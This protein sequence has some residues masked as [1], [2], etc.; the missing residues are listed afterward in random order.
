M[1][2]S[3]FSVGMLA[4]RAVS[5]ARRSRGLP[6]GSPPPALAATVISRISLVQLAARLLSVIAFLRLICFHLLCPATGHLHGVLIGIG[7][8]SREPGI[9]S[10]SGPFFNLKAPH[11]EARRH[12]EDP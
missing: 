7:R 4:A 8:D 6:A 1:A 12:G 11:A 3:M 10:N 9:I 2:R 5:I